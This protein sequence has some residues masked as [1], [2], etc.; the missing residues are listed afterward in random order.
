M[1]GE[2]RSSKCQDHLLVAFYLKCKN[3]DNWLHHWLYDHNI[4]GTH[5]TFSS[6]KIREK[7]IKEMSHFWPVD[8]DSIPLMQLNFL[9]HLILQQHLLT[10]ESHE[11]TH[12]YYKKQKKKKKAVGF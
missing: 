9:A 10:T 1:F 5:T 12:C 8:Y 4:Q 3:W 2:Y 7:F 6:K 11:Y